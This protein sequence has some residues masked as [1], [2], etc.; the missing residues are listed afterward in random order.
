MEEILDYLVQIFRDLD[1]DNILFNDLGARMEP[2]GNTQ[3]NVT[4]PFRSQFP[5]RY[6][7]TD[8]ELAVCFDKDSDPA[9]RKITGR[10]GEY[11]QEYALEMLVGDPYCP[12]KVDV[13]Y[14]GQ[15]LNNDMNTEVKGFIEKELKATREDASFD[16]VF[17]TYFAED[18]LDMD[19]M[20][21]STGGAEWIPNI[22][23]RIA[24]S[25]LVMIAQMQSSTP[26][27]RPTLQELLD[28]I[29]SLQLKLLP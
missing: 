2:D 8:F 15:M 29:T 28:D 6:Y 17:G 27:Q 23:N 16:D 21:M 3:A 26:E 13:W 5:I 7:I 4:W 18:V 11:A 25:L 9:S 14:L 19:K 1:S 22:H 10:M 24:Y 20:Y 12:F